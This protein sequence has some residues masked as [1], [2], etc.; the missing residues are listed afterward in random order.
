MM[1]D[2]DNEY[3]VE[4]L[5][6][7]GIDVVISGNLYQISFF[8]NEKKFELFTALN[9][10]FPYEF[11]K[12]YAEG[13]TSDYID[14]LLHVNP[15]STICCFNES[16][17]FPNPSE[18]NEVIIA[19]FLQAK[20]IITEGINGKNKEDFL[21]EFNAYWDNV[22]K[23]FF[24]L[25]TELPAKCKVLYYN[26]SDLYSFIC[27]DKHL[28]KEKLKE[29]AVAG[30]DAELLK[31][32]YVPL[33][34]AI[35]EIPKTHQDINDIIKNNSHYY[36]DYCSFL[37]KESL[38]GHLIIMSLE[39]NGS[40]IVFGVFHKRIPKLN[41]FRHGHAPLQLALINGLGDEKIEKYSIWD[42]TQKRLFTRGGD[43][44]KRDI[45][46]SVIGCGSLGGFL[47][48]A[49]ASCGVSKFKLIDKESISEDNI[50][51]HVCGFDSIGKKKVIALKHELL[52]HNPNIEFQVYEK[53]A[54][55]LLEKELEFLN[56]TD[57]II[58]TAADAPLEKHLT[59]FYNQ[60]KI[61]KRLAIMWVEAYALCGHIILL[62]KPQNI[63]DELYDKQLNFCET[64]IKASDS[65]LKR[66]AGCQSTYMP[67]SGLNVNLFVSSFVKDYVRGRYKDSCNYHII[68][69]GDLKN[70]LYGVEIN[71]KWNCLDDN[72]VRVERIK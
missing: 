71:K 21:D 65:Y 36:D 64:V 34:K 17:C 44:I 3:I 26:W 2:L 32:L 58:C 48:N 15:D 5:S 31:C 22:S 9:E 59:D 72:S 8:V 7:N 25:L 10:L 62:N 20:K 68:W 42:L 1:R 55:S 70:N 39:Y 19:C 14:G 38:Q 61:G 24:Y 13:E 18:P 28:L 52:F 40:L 67:Y 50:A 49:F 53:S 30:E 23:K 56:N 16:K 35:S 6:D 54:N 47:V 33:Y 60:G 4:K 66:E 57:I 37:K 27:T 45:T 12:I 43:G 46:V 29:L 11:P 63:F 69:T 41:G 51:R